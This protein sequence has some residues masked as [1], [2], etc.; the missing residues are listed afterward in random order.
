VPVPVPVPLSVLAPSCRAMS[1]RVLR[2][3]M[4]ET[5]IVRTPPAEVVID[6]VLVRALIDAQY[7]IREPRPLA[8]FA[9]GWDNAVW[10]LGSDL[11]VRLPRREL[12]APL[13]LHEHRWLP[14]LA[15]SLPLP[16]PAPV[17]VGLPDLGFPWHW[18]IVPLLSGSQASTQVPLS[19]PGAARGLAG[20]LR[21]LHVPAPPEAPHN[22]W[23]AVP[24]GAR[25]DIFAE[26]LSHLGS[27]IVERASV[28]WMRATSAPTW[29]GPS[30]WIHGD[31]H[32]GNV[33]VE[34]GELSGVIDFGDLT[35]GDPATDLAAAWLLFE[36][37]LVAEVLSWYGGGEDDALAARARGWALFFSVLLATIDDDVRGL[38]E[39][40]RGC[41]R[42]LLGVS[43]PN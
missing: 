41:L 11:L 19:S 3:S 32:P 14:Q 9:E 31:L 26:R 5:E 8:F 15:P 29:P 37:P 12:A 6:E 17:F 43:L 34:S 23:R 4:I 27:E 2:T 33:L 16:I 30:V 39:V 25:A 36:A 1:W 21:A 38:R 10:R 42:R 13:A 22:P 20:F 28:P 35:A 40:G 7:P 24:L 18:S